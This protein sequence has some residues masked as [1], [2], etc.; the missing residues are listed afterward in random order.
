[1]ARRAPRP[2]MTQQWLL[3]K[4][5]GDMQARNELIESY[6][7]LVKYVAGRLKTGL[8]VNVEQ[9]DL[10]SYGVF[11]LIDAIDKF[12]LK[13]NIKFETYA[14][15]RI[16]GAIID[17]IRS[18]DWVPRS[19][20]SKAREIDKAVTFLEAK[21]SRSPTH[22]EVAD[23][24]GIP[25]RDLRLAVGQVGTSSMVPLD[26]VLGSSLDGTV[27]LG[28]TLRDVSADDPVT[29]V[30]LESTKDSLSRAIT[31]LELRDR[32]VL[33]LY[34]LED[35]T[36]LQIGQVLGV[37]ESRVCQLHTRAVLNLRNMLAAV[38]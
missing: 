22:E 35:L 38:A 31:L 34:Y 37:T 4:R 27:T 10:V 32:I 25:V 33:S 16:R 2:D 24:L 20:R 13:R 8:P 18:L 30:E 14:M 7:D 5:T 3:F 11:G 1:M 29:A 21:L 9:D 28:D 26:E 23:Y 6:Y 19:V 12:D 15:S 36:L 17:E